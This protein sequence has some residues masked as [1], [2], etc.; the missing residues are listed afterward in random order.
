MSYWTS[1]AN[2]HDTNVVIWFKPEDHKG[3]LRALR[4]AVDKVKDTPGFFS[5][6]LYVQ[7]NCVTNLEA[8]P[9][10]DNEDFE[11]DSTWT[12]EDAETPP[13]AE[14]HLI[15]IDGSILKA[16]DRCFWFVV[17]NKADAEFQSDYFAWANLPEG[18]LEDK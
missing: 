12:Q 9:D 18:I 17:W 7:P 15:N 11:C 13:P 3:T 6:D 8:L 2:K 5:L 14:K 10:Y 1:I 16:D 4:A